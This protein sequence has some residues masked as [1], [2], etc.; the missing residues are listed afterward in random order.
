MAHTWFRFY[1]NAV[2]DPKVQRLHPVLFRF[3]VN[4]LCLASAN[5]GVIPSP[6]DAQFTLRMSPSQLSD[7]TGQLIAAGLLDQTEIGL[8]PHNWDDRQFKSDGSTERVK[9][10]RERSKPVS[11]TLDE[12]G[13]DQTRP[14]TESERKKKLSNFVVGKNGNGGSVTI[15]DP[16]ERLNRF[17]AWL[18]KSL[19]PSGWEMV[20]A[21]ADVKNPDHRE[22]LTRCKDQAKRLGKGW[23]RQWANGEG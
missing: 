2:N 17:Q 18:A 6:E 20:I 10:F 21:A 5:D 9:R 23:P 1:N 4:I 12:T 8:Q 15:L 11:E 22:M 14:E 3:W 7:F 13:P 19:G 16:K